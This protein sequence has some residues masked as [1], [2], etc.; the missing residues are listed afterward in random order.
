VEHLSPTPLVTA[1]DRAFASPYCAGP[2]APRHRI[3]L[4]TAIFR[5]ATVGPDEAR[6]HHLPIFL[7]SVERSGVDVTIVG[8]IPPEIRLPANV[9]HVPMT[10]SSLCD[11]VSE[12]VFGGDPVDHLRAASAYKVIDLKP[13]FGLLFADE[14]AGYDFWGEFVMLLNRRRWRPSGL[15]EIHGRD[16][17]AGWLVGRVTQ[18]FAHGAAREV[19]LLITDGRRQ[20]MHNGH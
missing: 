20:P 17:L 6:L 8:E 14:L 9:A 3:N 7:K 1:A 12:R 19:P 4:M 13:L 11:L 5:D 15:G 16:E 2:V 18:L 10:W